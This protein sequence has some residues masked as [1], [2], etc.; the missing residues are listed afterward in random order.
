MKIAI[1]NKKK[2]S[3]FKKSRRKYR[4]LDAEK[5]EAAEREKE[6]IKAAAM[7]DKSEASFEVR[8]I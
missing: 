6:E 5:R 1:H 8:V 7:V 2:A 4:K 3:K